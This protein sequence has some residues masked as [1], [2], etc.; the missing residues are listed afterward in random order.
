MGEFGKVSW[1]VDKKAKARTKQK[2][3]IEREAFLQYYRS[4][5]P[6]Q[7][8]NYADIFQDTYKYLILL[9]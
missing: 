6:E 5:L 7:L 3:V 8:F 9:F 1:K 2:P 4:K